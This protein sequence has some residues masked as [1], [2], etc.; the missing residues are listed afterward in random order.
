MPNDPERIHSQSVCRESGS[1]PLL[2]LMHACAFGQLC[3]ARCIRKLCGNA[4]ERIDNYV[5]LHPSA[6]DDIGFWTSHPIYITRYGGSLL[7]IFP[8]LEN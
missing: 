2:L 7:Y 1:S 4:R 6:S 8:A 5:S 3:G